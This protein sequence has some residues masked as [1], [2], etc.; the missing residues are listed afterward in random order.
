MS[1]QELRDILEAELAELSDCDGS[2]VTDDLDQSYT[3]EKFRDYEN[4]G[5]ICNDEEEASCLDNVEEWQELMSS[6][7]QVEERIQGMMISLSDNFESLIYSRVDDVGREM[8]IPDAQL[9]RSD[10]I[11]S[12][13]VELCCSSAINSA[14]DHPLRTTQ[15]DRGSNIL[16]ISYCEH[17]EVDSQE[18]DMITFEELKDLMNFIIEAV[19]RS[20]PINTIQLPKIG[21]RTIDL[22]SLPQEIKDEN[23]DH[24][25]FIGED[26][27]IRHNQEMKDK[28]D[29]HIRFI[30]LDG[31]IMDISESSHSESSDFIKQSQQS[32]INER[33][34]NA[35]ADILRHEAVVASERIQARKEVL[36]ERKRIMEEELRTHR[37]EV[38][39]VRY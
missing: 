29:D 4:V 14:R 17:E 30:G 8:Q 26:G 39:S 32:I 25:R 13:A 7:A 6:A 15:S 35:T 24:I 38:A 28:K 12:S 2:D 16:S 1:A 11:S 21:R 27:H 37:V 34:L 20:A 33:A 5:D 3:T 19:E 10:T 22:S 23:D 18:I 31:R 9:N 36:W